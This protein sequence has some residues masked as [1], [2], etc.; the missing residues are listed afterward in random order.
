MLKFSRLF[1]IQFVIILLKTEYREIVMPLIVWRVVYVKDWLFTGENK[2][3]GVNGNRKVFNLKIR[4]GSN[5]NLQN[6]RRALHFTFEI[7][8]LQK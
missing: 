8:K 6:K 4:N 3:K 5:N 7:Q 2:K 1:I